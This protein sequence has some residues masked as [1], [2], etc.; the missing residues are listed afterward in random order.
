[1]FQSC[2]VFLQRNPKHISSLLRNFMPECVIYQNNA[3]EPVASITMR[4]LL[5]SALMDVTTLMPPPPPAHLLGL[6][7]HRKLMMG[8][9]K[10]KGGGNPHPSG[11]SLG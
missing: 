1:M 2:I 8:E 3:I 7:S 5:D 4:D 9:H 6:V 10:H 11:Y